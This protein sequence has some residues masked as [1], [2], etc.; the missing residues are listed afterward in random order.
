[1]RTYILKGLFL[2]DSVPNNTILIIKKNKIRKISRLATKVDLPPE[3]SSYSSNL[4]EG[5]YVVSR[6]K[7]GVFKP[8]LKV[9]YRDTT[10]VA[11]WEYNTLFQSE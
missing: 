4:P 11:L 10:E 2:N 1:L 5:Q 3:F 8:H 6:C 9:E 7:Y